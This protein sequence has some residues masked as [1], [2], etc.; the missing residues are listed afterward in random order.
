M[1]FVNEKLEEFNKNLKDINVSSAGLF[2]MTGAEAC[3]NAVS[4]LCVDCEQN[5][6][7]LQSFAA[8]P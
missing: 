2:A 3:E 8:M 6:G 7:C 1:K 4:S 5:T